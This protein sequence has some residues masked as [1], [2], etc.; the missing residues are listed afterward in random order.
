MNKNDLKKILK[1]LIKECIKEV[2]FEDGTLS[3]IISEVAQ[4]LSSVQSV[5]P[6]QIIEK[7]AIKQEQTQYQTEALHEARKQL[8]ETK[9][10]LQESTGLKGI[11]EGTTP[12]RGGGSSSSSK[13]GALR[14]LDPAD[15]GVDISGIMK[16]AGGAWGQLK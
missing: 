13:H 9:K 10:S 2:I 16:V 12:M 11:F 5:A 8:E 1:P 4:G 6:Q 3:G 14:D 7:K 15:P